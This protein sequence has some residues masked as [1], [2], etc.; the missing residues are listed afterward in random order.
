MVLVLLAAREPGWVFS[1]DHSI[2]GR[3][4]TRELA[5][6]VWNAVAAVAH[7]VGFFKPK[8]LFARIPQ[9]IRN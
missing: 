8:Q 3:A 2:S 5:V 1:L 9:T 6:R 7:N 4:W